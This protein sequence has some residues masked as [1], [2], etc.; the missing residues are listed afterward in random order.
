MGF[1]DLFRALRRPKSPAEGIAPV[2]GSSATSVIGTQSAQSTA[3]EQSRDEARADQPSPLVNLRYSNRD[4]RLWRW[5]ESPVDHEIE[6]IVAN[7]AGLGQAERKVL[8]D[9]LT[10]DDYREILTFARRR[11]LGTLRSGNPAIIA[12]AFNALAMIDYDRID[13]RDLV[14]ASKLARYAALRLRMPVDD[15]VRSASQMA[16]PGIAQVLLSDQ[17]TRID[18]AR[19]CGYREIGTSAG[20]ALFETVLYG[21]RNPIPNATAARMLRTAPLWWGW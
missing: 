21:D 2:S 10:I 20:I 3:A 5:A 18:L 19:S 8:R 9:S 12:P 13:W 4:N 1:K 11:A 14:I 6:T 15:I 17:E 7:F 16:E